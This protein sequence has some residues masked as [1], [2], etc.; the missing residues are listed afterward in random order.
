MDMEQLKEL[1]DKKNELGK[2]LVY[3]IGGFI[4]ENWDVENHLLT[5]FQD[6]A[7]CERIERTEINFMLIIIKS[8]IISFDINIKETKKNI[9]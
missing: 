6:K 7:L 5:V 4:V 1:K 9:K 2:P 8:N 3:F